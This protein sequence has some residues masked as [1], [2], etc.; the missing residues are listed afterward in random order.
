[1][2]AHEQQERA[3]AVRPLVEKYPKGFEEDV[4]P[5]VWRQKSKVR[6]NRTRPVQAE[7]RGQPIQKGRIV[8]AP[9]AK[10]VGIDG[11]LLG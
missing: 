6:R 4:H 1:M 3:R 11:T 7:P 10:H 8:G 9:R 5:L 2:E